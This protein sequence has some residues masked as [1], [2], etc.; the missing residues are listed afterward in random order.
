MENAKK[1]KKIDI[2]AHAT[3]YP[4][5]TPNNLKGERYISPEELIDEYDRLGIGTGVLLPLVA[6]EGMITTITSEACKAMTERYPDRFIWFCN[7]CFA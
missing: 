6:A 4:E 5:Y 3:L 1:I 2:H 7:V